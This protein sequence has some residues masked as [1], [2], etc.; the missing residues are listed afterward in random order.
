MIQ[1]T[2]DRR[3][4]RTP[5]NTPLKKLRDFEIK[6]I[7]KTMD[8]TLAVMF[9]DKVGID[10][11]ELVETDYVDEMYVRQMIQAG[12]LTVDE[13]GLVKI[14]FTKMYEGIGLEMNPTI[15]ESEG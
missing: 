14:S 4:Q 12:F 11:K 2:H 5:N 8:L 3:N 9:G 1:T 15:D 7:A 10:Y 6:L 13:R